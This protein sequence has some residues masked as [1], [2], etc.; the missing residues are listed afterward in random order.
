MRCPATGAEKLSE[1]ASAVAILLG[2]RYVHAVQD[3]EAE[4]DTRVAALATAESKARRD[5]LNSLV[6]MA[7]EG[8]QLRWT[9]RG[10]V[11]EQLWDTHRDEYWREL[12]LARE[13]SLRV[14][15]RLE[16]VGTEVAVTGLQV[17]RD[18]APL[19]SRDLR[20][21][22]IPELRDLLLAFRPLVP[23]GMR[24]AVTAKRPG[25]KGH[26]PEHWADVAQRLAAAGTSGD[27][28]RRIRE[29]YPARTRP[30]DATA[31]RWVQRV[32]EMQQK[33]EL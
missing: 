33:G 26:P 13:T 14:R 12:H 6:A 18:G 19:T 16:P 25:R 5:Y 9:D 20:A 7:R 24:P 23:E 2:S 10:E 17:L 8:K 27:F 1:C 22:S 21:V 32:R 4:W 11:M 15:V 29:S 3:D 30:S 28:V 31:R